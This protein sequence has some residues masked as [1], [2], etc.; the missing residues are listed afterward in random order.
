MLINTPQ[1][2]ILRKR[3]SNSFRFNTFSTFCYLAKMQA[4]PDITYKYRSWNID[5]H[6]RTLTHNEVYFSAPKDLNDPQEFKVPVGWAS[7]TD[8]EIEFIAQG[9]MDR[10]PNLSLDYKQFIIKKIK[11]GD[12]I[13]NESNAFYTET[14]NLNLG[15]LS[16][17][18]E[19]SN[20][21]MWKDYGD[22]NR[23]FC[24]GIKPE[25]AFS[26]EP[27]WGEHINYVTE[28]P[29][30]NPVKETPSQHGYKRLFT[31]LECF[32]PESEYRILKLKHEGLLDSD[33]KHIIPHNAIVE[34]ILGSEMPEKHKNEILAITRVN[35]IKT[36]QISNSDQFERKELI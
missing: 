7:A 34:V 3:E 19:Y 8:E 5:L 32:R 22:A 6:K 26:T 23:G 2:H 11:S 20:K 16:L 28:L 14:D 4:Y 33:R 12:I 18:T 10:H 25:T 31:K 30:F 27:F 1:Q 36:Y 35:G 21:H 13:Q 29:S 24:I 9:H 17:C 15:V